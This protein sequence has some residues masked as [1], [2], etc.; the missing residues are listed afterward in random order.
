MPDRSAQPTLGAGDDSGTAETEIRAF[1]GHW[2]AELVNTSPVSPPRADVER[3]SDELGRHLV[4][5]LSAEPFD[6][7]PAEEIGTRLVADNFIDPRALSRTIALLHELPAPAG[8]APG[9]LAGRL[10][11][12]TDSIVTGYVGATRDRLFDEQE[13]IKL[14]VYHAS[15]VA[16]QRQRNSE[17]KF[18]AVVES[19]PSG[20]A[21]TGLNGRIQIANGALADL[22]G[23]ARG[24]LT[25]LPLVSLLDQEDVPAALLGLAK[26]A[27]GDLPVFAGTV[28]VIGADG[29]VRWARLRLSRLRDATVVL[30]SIVATIEDISDLVLLRENQLTWAL[31]DQLTGLPNR[32]QLIADLDRAI[33]HATPGDR[34]AL[35]YL[36]LD[37]FKVISDGAGRQIGDK[38]LQRV[39]KVLCAEFDGDNE[40][41]ARA[42]GDGFAVLI[43]GI[44]H[45]SYEIS[46]RIQRVLDELVE[47]VQLGDGQRAAV[48][49]SAGIVEQPVGGMT[50]EDL[51]RSAELTVHRAKA[52]GKAQWMLD[53]EDLDRRDRDEYRLAADL[54]VALQD[55]QFELSY[56][57]VVSLSG[58]GPRSLVAVRT[59]L[60]WRHPE[61]GVL[62]PAEFLGL[63]EQT[64]FVLPLQLWML[65]AVCAQLARWQRELGAAAP[66]V[67]VTLEARL[68]GD[69]DLVHHLREAV[70]DSGADPEKLLLGI[71]AQV[72]I[73]ERG[74]LLENLRVL[75]AADFQVFIDDFGGTEHRVVALGPESIRGVLVSHSV[76]DTI[77]PDRNDHIGPVD[78]RPLAEHALRGLLAFSRQRG[79]R[80]I[81]KGADTEAVVNRLIK[82]GVPYACGSA[83]GEPLSPD[84]VAAVLAG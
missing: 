48:L 75:A 13:M 60:H 23:R 80:M 41:V 35:C 82:L 22:L 34:I 62:R 53:D 8:L 76:V 64:G 31:R 49:A 50:S 56:Q 27:D 61:R 7:R 37:G 79:L 18:R 67:G 3:L 28:N 83:L 24:S 77:D 5:V 72:A 84:Q 20:M 66:A 52:G 40:V 55:G 10:A 51:L 71:P 32:T 11:A 42:G 2:A 54:P 69:Q 38:L 9:A 47:P 19:S 39:A 14:A 63:A 58:A 30:D 26:I 17:T 43:S 68:A 15:E 65:R 6:P 16:E 25:G 12:L 33:T 29:D 57:P 81:A 73:D 1:S 45:G 70:T 59:R 78:P 21:I 46:Q 36:D 4:S 44:T 74:E